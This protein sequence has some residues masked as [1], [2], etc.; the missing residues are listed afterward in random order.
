MTNDLFSLSVPGKVHH[1]LGA[2]ELLE[3][4]IARRE[5]RFASTGAF[6]VE[7]G[8]HTGRSAQD[9]FVVRDAT[10]DT[11]IWWDNNKSI[12]PA[13]FETLLRDVLA[14]VQSREMFVQDLYAGADPAHRLSTRVFTELAWH[15]L[16][17]RHMLRR[18]DRAELDAFVPEWTIV[19]CP[20]F[21]A[22]PVRHG[23]RTS[24][25]IALNFDAKLT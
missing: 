13:Q 10:T 7:T 23:C 8:A 12:T 17:I 21:K 25:V 11:E 3:H 5:G 16:F 22:D 6:V 18:P 15:S 2:V 14:H 19:N 4:A 9:K 1:N 20:G 24:T